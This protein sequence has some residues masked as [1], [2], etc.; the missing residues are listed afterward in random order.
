MSP[1]HKPYYAIALL[2]LLLWYVWK[3]QPTQAPATV[4]VHPADPPT[5]E[6]SPAAPDPYVPEMANPNNPPIFSGPA[7]TTT[8]ASF[9]TQAGNPNVLDITESSIDGIN[10]ANYD[11]LNAYPSTL[12][13]YPGRGGTAR[14]TYD[15]LM[16]ARAAGE[17]LAPYLAE[18]NAALHAIY[19]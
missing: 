18:L 4:I 11:K 1:N 13:F 5:P 12:A 19:G 2:L 7:D 8:G 17:P 15:A 14:G 6:P 9:Y 16:W 3:R 10:P